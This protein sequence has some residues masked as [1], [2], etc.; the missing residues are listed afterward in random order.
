MACVSSRK[1]RFSLCFWAGII[2]RPGR[3]PSGDS[4]SAFRPDHRAVP[5][6]G[7]RRFNDL[8]VFGESVVADP[9][10]IACMKVEAIA[11]RGSRRD[12]VDLYVAASQYGL[13]EI[14]DWFGKKYAAVSFSRTHVLKALT[15]FTDAEEEPPPH[16]LLPLDWSTVTWYFR[17]EVLSRR[18]R[19]QWCSRATR[20]SSWITWSTSPNRKKL[21]IGEAKRV[22]NV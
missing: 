22:S 21:W 14:L 19:R 8:N 7:D 5:Y 16:L 12:F 1:N 6:F 17:S 18:H 10:D 2:S 15:Y 3:R 11:N 20:I 9:R 4:S 13:A